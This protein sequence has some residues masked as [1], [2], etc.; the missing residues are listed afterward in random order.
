MGVAAYADVVREG[1]EAVE[2]ILKGALR[3]VGVDPPKRHDV[4]ALL[5]Q[6]LDRLP[7]EWAAALEHLRPT[8]DELSEDRSLAFYGDEERGVPASELFSEED[9]RRALQA[10]DRLLE[11]FERLLVEREGGAGPP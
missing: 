1:Q 3:S 7:R 9:A 10:V 11:M 4:H 6:F 8:L 2:L 5:D